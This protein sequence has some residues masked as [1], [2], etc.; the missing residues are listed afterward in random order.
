MIT[1]ILAVLGLLLTQTLLVAGLKVTSSPELMTVAWS[2]GPR[3]ERPAGSVMSARAERALHN[4]AESLPY[5]LVLALLVLHKQ[6]DGGLAT[7]GA[8]V[9]FCA[10]VAYVPAYLSGVLG[11]R[12]L[13]W[14]IGW[15]GLGMMVT[16]ILST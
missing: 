9:F 1:W 10:R 3:D 4:L 13:C 7:T 6:V 11:I 16:A 12:S 14:T 2:L 5:F 8:M 15:V